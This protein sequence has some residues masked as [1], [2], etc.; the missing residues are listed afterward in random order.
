MPTKLSV[1]V[2]T[3]IGRVRATNEDAVLFA[4]LAADVPETSAGV[5]PASPSGR[6]APCSSFPAGMGGHKAG[7]VASRMTIESLHRSLVEQD[8]DGSTDERI[9]QAVEHANREVSAAGKR[10]SLSN[11]GATVTA[12]LVVDGE[13]HIAEVGDSRA[14]L[15]RGG[16][17][18]QVTEDQSFVQV[19]VNATGM[20][21]EDA[22]A[23]SLR[24]CSFSP[25]AIRRTCRLRS[26]LSRSSEGPPHPLLRRPHE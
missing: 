24:V 16:V 2:R 18:R 20:S 21:A 19:M 14:Y 17:L 15:L 12:I 8:R 13:A 6:R 5:Y 11:M 1:A 9:R 22:N 4:D 10:P 23:S 3:D 7:E 26:G 25:S